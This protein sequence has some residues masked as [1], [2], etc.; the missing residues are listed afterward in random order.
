LFVNIV[1]WAF[2]SLHFQFIYLFKLGTYVVTY[3]DLFFLIGVLVFAYDLLLGKR[4]LK[5]R[6]NGLHLPFL[7]FILIAC[8]SG[9]QPV[10]GEGGKF[11]TQFLKSYIHLLEVFSM[12]L[13]S[14]F[15]DDGA[16]K[17]WKFL[18][19]WLI[20]GLLSNLYA[21][22]GLIAR[23]LDWP[24]AYIYFGNITDG[25][26]TEHSE[27]IGQ[28]VLSYGDF[29][30]ATSF[31]S[32]PSALAIFNVGT[33]LFFFIP[34]IFTGKF[35]IQSKL[36][37]TLFF[38]TWIPAQLF[39]FSLTAVLLTASSAFI[40]LLI[41]GLP[42]IKKLFPYALLLLLIALITDFI[43][44]QYTD[45][46]ILELL[47][48]RVS[49]V[50]LFDVNNQVMGES[51]F[52]RFSSYWLALDIWEQYPLVGTGLGLTYLNGIHDIPF[53]HMS[54]MAVLTETG[55]IGLVVYLWAF[56]YI[57]FKIFIRARFLYKNSEQYED[58]FIALYVIATILT[59]NLLISNIVVSNSVASAH[60][61]ITL[62]II[63]LIY[64]SEQRLRNVSYNIIKPQT[65]HRSYLAKGLKALRR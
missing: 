59:F 33:I 2:V 22:Y 64:Q 27:G 39:T 11:V 44:Y 65:N 50:L 57:T 23:P 31:F 29:F 30:R 49:S 20:V 8:V 35:L 34:K 24:G 46:M 10:I 40:L 14:F 25:G 15:Y 9:L 17:L 51:A 38:I 7:A 3:T 37:N 53:M 12:F 16:K 58:W 19:W 6:S 32:E 52:D 56:I 45:T 4:E 61:W 62:S 41:R 42:F 1:I 48:Q 63:I 26:R 36:F 13:L 21:I 18:K 43:Q 28:I 54:I 55:I 47:S 5:F 60:Q